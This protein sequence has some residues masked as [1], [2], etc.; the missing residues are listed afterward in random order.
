MNLRYNGLI[1]GDDAENSNNV[2]ERLNAMGH[3][4]DRAFCIEKARQLVTHKKYDYVILD[5]ELPVRTGGQANVDTG[6]FFLSSLR[7]HYSREDL[8][9]IAIAAKGDGRQDVGLASQVF[10]RGATDLLLKPLVRTGEHTLESSILKFVEKRKG[11]E[12]AEGVQQEWLFRDLDSNNRSIIH[13]RTIA[14]NGTEHRY[15]V[16]IN[17]IRGRLL[18]CINKMRFKNSMI[19]HMDLITASGIWSMK[20]YY[21]SKG[22]APRGPLKNHVATFRRELGMKI[23]YVENGITVEQPEE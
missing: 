3:L 23:T 21:P 8:P 15:T 4:C 2:M 12:I 10:F 18:D 16:A 7:D 1:V 9:I 5:M 6:V 20:T 19:C 22:G 17:S 14:K 11:A 13:W